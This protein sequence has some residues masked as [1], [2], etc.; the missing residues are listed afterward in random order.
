MTVFIV[1]VLLI[2]NIPIIKRLIKVIFPEPDGFQE[3]IRYCFTPD[4]IS[5]FRGE[6][7]KDRA[8]ELV[9]NMLVT[10]VGLLIFVEYWLLKIF[11]LRPVFGM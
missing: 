3:A 2:L 10:M 6:Y 1:I 5:F 8:N 7:F 11:L 9:M 4:I